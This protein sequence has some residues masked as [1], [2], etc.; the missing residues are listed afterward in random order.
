MYK[1]K[2]IFVTKA[3]QER[4]SRSMRLVLL[5]ILFNAWSYDE[6]RHIHVTDIYLILRSM[7]AIRKTRRFRNHL[8]ALHSAGI[9]EFEGSKKDVVSLLISPRLPLLILKLIEEVSPDRF[10]FQERQTEFLRLA[11][12]VRKESNLKRESAPRRTSA[13]VPPSKVSEA[14]NDYFDKRNAEKHPTVEANLNKAD[15][16]TYLFTNFD[17]IQQCIDERFI[18]F[19]GVRIF[20]RL[21]FE[22]LKERLLFEDPKVPLEHFRWNYE[23]VDKVFD[24]LKAQYPKD[25]LNGT[26]D[27]VCDS[28]VRELDKSPGIL[29]LIAQSYFP[30][31]ETAFIIE[32]LKDS[33]SALMFVVDTEKVNPDVLSNLDISVRDP[34]QPHRFLMA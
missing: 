33:P 11:Q 25:L 1:H 10:P 31:D 29:S 2:L 3:G 8:K 30:P 14:V 13:A 21:L 34:V 7:F 32:I 20:S 24:T 19:S 5:L 26:F 23:C 22:D 4:H 27:Y 9:I 6:H 17:V 28:I 15:M 18:E 12:K 16:F